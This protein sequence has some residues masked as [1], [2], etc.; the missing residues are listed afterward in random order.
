MSL[1]AAG[2]DAVAVAV[3]T[4]ACGLKGVADAIAA[5]VPKLRAAVVK[6][7][8]SGAVRILVG[9]ADVFDALYHAALDVEHERAGCV[10]RQSEADI[11]HELRAATCSAAAVAAW[12]AWHGVAD[13][14]DDVARAWDERGCVRR[15]G[16]ERI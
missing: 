11:R 14:C 10:G 6:V 8:S 5:A 3:A 16:G 9:S 2:L 13:D 7:E 4:D 1:F 12:A 15:A